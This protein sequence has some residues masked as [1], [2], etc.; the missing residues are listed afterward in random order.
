M[1]TT[2]LFI[3]ALFIIAAVAMGGGFFF[4]V[5]WFRVQRPVPNLNGDYRLAGLEENVQVRRDKHGVPFL[6]AAS[7]TDLYRAQ[8][9]VHAQDRLWQMEQNRRTAYG[10]LAELFGEAALEADRFSRIIGFGR[11]AQRELDALDD[12]TRATLEQYAAGVNAFIE[13]HPGRLG[14]EFNLLRVK[15]DPWTP[16]DSLACLKMIA[17]ALSVNWESEL[18][19]L[20]LAQQMT[21][22]RAAELAPGYPAENPLIMAGAGSAEMTRL[23]DA[24]GL[25]LN[26]YE[27]VKQWLKT[28]DAGKG[29]NSWVVAPDR[30]LNARPLLCC[31]PHLALQLPGF[32]YENDLQ[33]PEQRV[34]GASLA[35][36]PGVLIGHNDRIAWGM[37]NALV[38]VQDLYV[39]RPHPTEADRFAWQDGWEEAT[40]VEETIRVKGGA[41]RTERVVITRHGP[42]ISSLTAAASDAERLPALAVRWTGQEA[43]HSVRA[44]L[45]LN[46][47]QNWADFQHALADWDIAS[48]NFTYADVDGNIGYL[49]AGRIP[50]RDERTLGLTPAPGWDGKH[51]WQGLIPCGELP[52]L[53]NPPSGIIVTANNKITGDDYPYF[54]GADY[55][56]GWRAA[57]IQELLEKKARYALRDMADI[58]L[59]TG[60][61]YAAALAPWLSLLNSDDPWEKG[62]LHALRNWNYRMEADSEAALVFHYTLNYLLEMVFGDKIGPARAGY[63]GERLSPLLLLHDFTLQAETRLLELLSSQ[64]ASI[65]YMEGETRRE[66]DREELLQEALTRAVRDIRKEMGDSRRKWDWGRSHQVR[67]SHPLGSARFLRVF[68]NR[69]PFPLAGDGTT[70]LMSRQPPRL[71]LGLIQ[72]TPSY[73]QLYEAGA[74]DRAQTITTAGQSG[75]PLSDHFDDQIPMFLEGEYR[76]MPWSEEA[77]EAA[78]VF[79]MTLRPG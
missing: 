19:R 41:S 46:R 30:S 72:V 73:R 77:V 56:P 13:T 15:P 42:L 25:L 17:W 76:G 12:A 66:R 68:F 31:D 58:Q 37:T 60:S 64:A 11:A 50:R 1:P 40:V 36:L 48:Q 54:L 79:K 4:Y 52:R 74:W 32:W 26:Q 29:S 2:L 10:T 35:G 47:A 70:P 16:L 65:W 3:I 71:P 34:S 27:Q 18:T 24:A 69:G 28:A 20:R 23:I 39:E 78:T 21:P 43:G 5:Y 38:D 59:D 45:R 51:E 14:A 9:F 44:V 33:A 49:L 7:Q 57:R 22:L 61:A 62:A 55:D 63:R 6:C 67:Y 53:Y 8:G 75:H